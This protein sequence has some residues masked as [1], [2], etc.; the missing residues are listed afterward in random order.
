VNNEE[1]VAPDRVEDE[2][3]EMLNHY[4]DNKKNVF[5]LQMAFDMHLRYEKIHPFV[6]GN[7]R[8]GRFLMNKVLMKG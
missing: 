5:P 6:N 1:T 4:R 8:T 7:G 3:Q 2:I